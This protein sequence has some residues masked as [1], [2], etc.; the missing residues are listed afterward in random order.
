MQQCLCGNDRPKRSDVE[1]NDSDDNEG[2]YS[3]DQAEQLL[4]V[5][6]DEEVELDDN[7]DLDLL[8]AKGN[9]SKMKN[10]LAAEIHGSICGNVCLIPHMADRM[11]G[12]QAHSPV[13]GRGGGQC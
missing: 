13:F 1:V 10:I 12:S 4:D 7:E 2:L 6:E 11:I 5:S 9:P 3:E 8:A